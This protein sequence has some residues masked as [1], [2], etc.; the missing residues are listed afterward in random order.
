MILDLRLE[1]LNV[2]GVRGIFAT[3]LCELSAKRGFGSL[4]GLQL[5]REVLDLL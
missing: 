5:V 4:V 2:D 3:R 1:S